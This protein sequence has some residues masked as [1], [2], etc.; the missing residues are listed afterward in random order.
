METMGSIL[1]ELRSFS[2][3]TRRVASKPVAATWQRKPARTNLISPKEAIMTP[4]TMKETLKRV[5]ASKG[6]ILRDQVITRT[7]T[8]FVAFDDCQPCGV[9]GL[10]RA[11][12]E[13]LD[14]S[15]AEVEVCFVAEYQAEREEEADWEDGAN[16]DLSVHLQGMA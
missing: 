2:M 1:K 16:I 11:Y 10:G 9:Y 15:Y 13:H 7:T 4:R 6:F 3:R 14:E 12:F 5:F 8:G